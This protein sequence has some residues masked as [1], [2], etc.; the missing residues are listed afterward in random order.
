MENSYSLAY[1]RDWRLGLARNIRSP[2]DLILLW[3]KLLLQEAEVDLFSN[4]AMKNK[5]NFKLLEDLANVLPDCAI[6]ATRA[7]V[8]AGYCP[9][10]MQVGQTGK[11]VAPNLYLAFGVSGAIQH[12]AG[13]KDSK[14]IVAVNTDA[15][16]PIFQYADYGLVGDLYKI[17]PELTEKLKK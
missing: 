12:I 7:A 17:V 5:E 3:L 15:D 6:G 2:E 8:D 14:V 11:I 1:L 10:E 4:S 13:M 9:N 16:A